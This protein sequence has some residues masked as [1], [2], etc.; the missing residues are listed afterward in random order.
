MDICTSCLEKKEMYHGKKCRECR[1]KYK[2][3]KW[4]EKN[5]KTCPVC[6]FQH[7]IRNTKECSI[8]CKILN[9]HEKIGECWE[10][11]GKINL[12]G[13]GCFQQLIN[14]KK[15][16]MLS[17]RESYKIFKGEI[18]L[19]LYVC[20]HCDNPSCCNPDHLFLGTHSDNM[21]DMLRKGRQNYPKRS[22]SGM[23]KLNENDVLEI[24]KLK[25]MGLSQ[26][27][28]SKKYGIS[29]GHVS[30]IINRKYWS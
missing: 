28:I 6:N 30:C 7:N 15:K 14:G 25:N 3:E 16:D 4:L 13:Y 23:A 19:G 17:H 11:K 12:S 27:E 5:K 24:R 20:H 9:R 8:K 10:W 26:M 18:P 29:Q 2:R 1:V 22:I 21:Q